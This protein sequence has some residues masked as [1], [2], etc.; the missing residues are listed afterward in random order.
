MKHFLFF[1][2]TFWSLTLTAQYKT[3]VTPVK[4]W[5]LITSPDFLSYS[6]EWNDFLLFPRTEGQEKIYS[7]LMIDRA[8]DDVHL[9]SDIRVATQ[10][11]DNHFSLAGI[12][13]AGRNLTAFVESRN[14]KTG[15]NVMAMQAVDNNGGLTSEGMLVGYFD[16]E[17]KEQ[18]GTWHISST[19]DQKSIT[20]IAQLPQE[21]SG[22][23]RFK[24]FFLNEN[25]TIIHKGEFAVD[26][27][28]DEALR[29]RQ[30]L[31]SNEGEMFIIAE[32]SEK[33]KWFPHIYKSNIKATGSTELLLNGLDAGD[34]NSDCRGIINRNGE[35][36]VAGYR[37]KKT[38]PE[39]KTS[40]IT[41]TWMFSSATGV[42]K[43]N[44]ISAASLSLKPLN[45]ICNKDT[46]F[47]I[48]QTATGFYVTGFA[49]DGLK[50]FDIPV[51]SNLSVGASKNES[52]I[53]SGIL[54]GKLCLVY[55]ESGVKVIAINNEGISE[56]GATVDNLAGKESSILPA[57][58]ANDDH[59][60]TLSK[61]ESQTKLIFIR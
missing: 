31:P 16:F 14:F 56:P 47:L 38:I 24:Y 6:N 41:G 55:N 23:E 4:S 26:H 52:W 8:T 32:G 7:L 35:L 33:N 27:A 34:E 29:I 12:A 60:L 59:I 58:V 53:A 37:R 17:K 21:S 25:L 3:T 43:V 51:S 54:Q 30:F 50:K 2:A 10:V 1:L 46:Y 44:A 57:Y 13:L 61:T 20:L 19:P 40:G 15:R 39:G 11:G 28:E 5:P 18:P 45:L 36:I 22:R 48:G 42:V 9:S 49:S